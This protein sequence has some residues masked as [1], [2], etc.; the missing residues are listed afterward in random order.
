MSTTVM[1][2]EVDLASLATAFCQRLHAADMLVTPAQSELY[3]RSLQLTQPRSR[4]ALYFTTRAIFVTDV[5]QLPAF[6]EV[7]NEVF[8]E[9]G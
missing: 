4:H 1:T 6:D 5:D 3:A 9:R 7:F 2:H 8:G